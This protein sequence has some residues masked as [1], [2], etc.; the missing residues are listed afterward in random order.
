MIAPGS[1]ERVV[2]AVWPRLAGNHVGGEI[3]GLEQPAQRSIDGSVTDLVQPGRA[4]PA[5]VACLELPGV[6]VV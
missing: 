3:A 5:Q 6:V 4:Q 2:L 1:V